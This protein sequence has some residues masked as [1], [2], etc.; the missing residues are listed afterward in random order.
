MDPLP[1]Y[2]YTYNL[3]NLMRFPLN[4]EPQKRSLNHDHVTSC[5]KCS[6]HYP[7]ASTEDSRRHLPH[8]PR[9][10]RAP[11]TE[12]ATAASS[13]A[14]GSASQPDKMVPMNTSTLTDLMKSV[15][16]KTVELSCAAAAE[17]NRPGYGV[18]RGVPMNPLALQTHP[19]PHKHPMA[20]FVWQIPPQMQCNTPTLWQQP[21]MYYPRQGLPPCVPGQSSTWTA[22]GNSYPPGYSSKSAFSPVSTSS[23]SSHLQDHSVQ[24]QHPPGVFPFGPPP[25]YP[26]PPPVPTSSTVMPKPE[27]PTAVNVQPTATTAPMHI[28]MSMPQSHSVTPQMVNRGDSALPLYAGYVGASVGLDVTLPAL[29]S[30]IQE[31]M[32]PRRKVVKFI[33]AKQKEEHGACTSHRNDSLAQKSRD[34]KAPNQTTNVTECRVAQAHSSTTLHATNSSLG[35]H[36]KEPTKFRKKHLVA[37][38]DMELKSAEPQGSL[39]IDSSCEDLSGQGGHK[40]IYLGK[41]MMKMNFCS[42]VQSET[43]DSQGGKES[44]LA[45]LPEAVLGQR[46]EDNA[47]TAAEPLVA[48]KITEGEQVE[49]IAATPEAKYVA[50]GNSEIGSNQSAMQ[51]AESRFTQNLEEQEAATSEQHNAASVVFKIRDVYSVTKSEFDTLYKTNIGNDYSKTENESSSAATETIG[52]RDARTT[53]VNTDGVEHPFSSGSDMCKAQTDDHEMQLS[54]GS[55]ITN[56]VFTEMF[57]KG[58]SRKTK[59]SGES[60]INTGDDENCSESKIP[61]TKM[62]GNEKHF[63]TNRPKEEVIDDFDIILKIVKQEDADATDGGEPRVGSPLRCCEIDVESRNTLASLLKVKHIGQLEATRGDANCAIAPCVG[64]RWGALTRTPQP[65]RPIRL[66]RSRKSWVQPFGLTAIN[67]FRDFKNQGL[68]SQA[69]EWGKASPEVKEEPSF[70]MSPSTNW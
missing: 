17:G 53:I 49:A 47:A 44:P 66:E 22:L 18:F 26:A 13:A 11:S 60:G 57:L 40:S 37:L 63:G 32:D 15:I 10:V 25:L 50:A 20:G 42:S 46:L 39:I 7:S 19:Y 33:A 68:E 31:G 6:R 43:A 36:N 2:C 9:S 45:C 52:N 24:H 4:E 5:L 23:S 29:L 38:W 51:V 55:E 69:K 64:D 8:R 28:P 59:H 21:P 27:I 62:K 70:A 58:R 1:H 48:M 3:R 65:K 34:E 16:N 30:T 35:E 12:P 14:P 61:R 67:H 54:S 41:Q 56:S